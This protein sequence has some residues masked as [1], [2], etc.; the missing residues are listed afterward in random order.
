[1]HTT[2]AALAVVTVGYILAH[3]VFDK[4][5]SRL[6]YAGGAEYLLLGF[7]LG[8]RVSGFL[9]EDAVRDL[10]PLVSLAL[11]WLG[12][13]LGMYFRLPTL[14]L[15]ESSYLGIAFAEALGTFVVALGLLFALFHYFAG[16]PIETTLVA[17]STLAAIAT[18]SSPAAI[19]AFSGQPEARGSP[20]LSRAAVDGP[21]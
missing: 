10:T 9:S 11:G 18:L 3:F 19:D 5:R 16:F 12:L 7:L 21:D 1:M 2:L 13:S 14:A 4:L 20:A 15:V 6:G 17:A 8:P